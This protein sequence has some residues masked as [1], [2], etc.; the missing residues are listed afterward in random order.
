MLE[1]GTVIGGRYEIQEKIG[2]GGM[3]YV[4]RAKDTKLERNVTLKVLKE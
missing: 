3:A 2:T 4:Y 1:A